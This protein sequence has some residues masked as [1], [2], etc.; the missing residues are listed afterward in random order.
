MRVVYF[1][2]SL[3]SSLFIQEGGLFKRAVLSRAYGLCTYMENFAIRVT[4][5][6]IKNKKEFE[7][8]LPNCIFEMMSTSF[9][10]WVTK[11]WAQSSLTSLNCSSIRR[12][13]SQLGGAKRARFPVITFLQNHLRNFTSLHFRNE[14]RFFIFSDNWQKNAWGTVMSITNPPSTEGASDNS[15]R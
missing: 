1:T 12:P 10:I 9:G 15:S 13:K 6:F 8:F 5:R 14:V 11:S 7:N 4:I 3:L 2:N